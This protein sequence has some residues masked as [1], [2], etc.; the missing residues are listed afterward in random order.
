MLNVSHQAIKEWDWPEMTMD[1][2]VA[3]SVDI[4]L[5]KEDMTLH[6]EIEKN[7]DGNYEVI[8]VHIPDDSMNMG[9]NP[10]ADAVNSAT[11]KGVINS[12]MTGHRMLNISREAIE[13][14]GREAATLD[15]MVDESVNMSELEN[16]MEIQFTFH[17]ADGEFLITD[18][19]RTDIKSS[20]IDN[21]E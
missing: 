21:N 12:V 10:E 11:V 13:A 9:D 6:I 7:S 17:L 14:W 15:F 18:I 8:N 16:E 5:L 4:N 1:F 19:K 2:T 3:E 20:S